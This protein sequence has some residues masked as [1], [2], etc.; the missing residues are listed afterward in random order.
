MSED[1]VVHTNLGGSPEVTRHSGPWVLHG[2]LE[3]RVQCK[4]LVRGL[5]RVL[6]GTHLCLTVPGLR[7]LLRLK[8]VD[9]LE[10]VQ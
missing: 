3:R 7:P 6:A 9:T 1:T 10:P 2:R 5:N 8:P 4:G